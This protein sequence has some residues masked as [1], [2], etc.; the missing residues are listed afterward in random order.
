MPASC[1]RKRRR[2]ERCDAVRQECLLAKP[3]EENC[4]PDGEIVH[5][6]SRFAERRELR[7]DF[8]VAQD[9]PGDQPWKKRHENRVAEQICPVYVAALD[10]RKIA[11]LLKGEE[12]NA[13]RQN[14][15]SERKVRARNPIDILGK[16]VCILEDP[17]ND[18]IER[19]AKHQPGSACTGVFLFNLTRE[20]LA[21]RVVAENRQSE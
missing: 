12:R 8:A 20:S 15:V 1:R 13:E 7:F 3:D 21:D 5:R 9:R 16:K 17:Q 11:D 6:K 10:I 18:E 4:E 14:D 2:H 19:Y